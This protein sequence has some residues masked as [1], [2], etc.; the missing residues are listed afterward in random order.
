MRRET[1]LALLDGVE[2]HDAFA[3]LLAFHAGLPQ[4]KPLEVIVNHL[5]D[6]FKA[7]L[8][9]RGVYGDYDPLILL[10][11][12]TALIEGLLR[13]FELEWIP[14][15]LEEY[16]ILTIEKPMDW[17]LTPGLVEKLRFDVVMRRITDGQLV[18]LDYK[19]MSRGSDA[20]ARKLER[21]R[22]TSLYI[23]AAQELFGESVEISYLG[24]IKGDS[25]KDT[26]MNSA[27]YNQRIQYSPFC[28]AYELK[29][30]IGSV[31]T[32]KYT[33][34]KGFRKVRIYESLPTKEWVKWLWDN[35]RSV[36]KE[37]FIYAP[38]FSPTPKEL[39]RVKDLVIKEELEYHAK[40]EIYEKA[41]NIAIDNGDE[42][43][44]IE[45]ERYLDL[46]AAPMRETSCFQYGSE[47]VCPFYEICF[48]D[49]AIYNVLEDGA[50][51]PREA[52]HN[53]K[54]EGDE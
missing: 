29:G 30:D 3:E 41:L 9:S 52:H 10:D 47:Y 8:D 18:I 32:S 48:N 13:S 46:E 23:N 28:Y 43:A 40:R 27:F 50:F 24:V 38:P 5:R 17:M 39:A 26:A 33:N 45:A 44:L 4:G 14:R 54:L 51:V 20:W 7:T 53:T 1:T 11:E 37:S 42:D 6:S 49:G 12:Q 31:Y 34:K 15:L 2:L 36:V 25:R 16:D 35:E 22:Q 19:T 21:S